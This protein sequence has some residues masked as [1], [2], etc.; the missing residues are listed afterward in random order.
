M[1]F[2]NFFNSLTNLITIMILVLFLNNTNSTK[3]TKNKKNFLSKNLKTNL[4]TNSNTN[5]K[6][7]S[8]INNQIKQEK[9]PKEISK[10]FLNNLSKLFNKKIS[11]FLIKNEINKSALL[12]FK[13]KKTPLNFILGISEN[14]NFIIR[15]NNKNKIN[16]LEIDGKNKITLRATTLS[17]NSLKIKGDFKFNKI[18]QWK[19]FMQDN[20][21][22]NN[23]SL[24]W[25]FN[26]ITKCKY[27]NMLGGI[28]Q[29]SQKEIS[30]EI[31]NLPHHKEIKIVAAYHFIGKWDSN[32]GY[33]KLDGLNSKRKNPQYVW[34]NRC[35]SKK[36]NDFGNKNRNNKASKISKVKLC[37]FDVCRIND[38]VN[39]SL[40]HSGNYLKLIFGSTLKGNSCDSSYAISD[41]KIFIR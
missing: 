29:T 16:N 17:I 28:C 13:I 15:N 1:K 38:I 24:N 31:L 35:V 18:S 32:T 40:L 22:K 26:K 3:N 7:I 21:L 41:V 11:T 9:K 25:D 19:L 33:L 12:N 37:D 5:K 4:N 27:Y 36:D 23:T 6:I 30:K 20:F 10:K 8:K 14:K 2:N 34:S 39:V